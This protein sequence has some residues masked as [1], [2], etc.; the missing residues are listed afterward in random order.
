MESVRPS[1][2]L[3]RLGSGVAQLTAYQVL[4]MWLMANGYAPMITFAAHRVWFVLAL[5]LIPTWSA[6]HFYLVH[7]LSHARHRLMEIMPLSTRLSSTRA[8]P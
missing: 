1:H 5:I 8:R 3:V 4:T 6:F 7:R 2:L